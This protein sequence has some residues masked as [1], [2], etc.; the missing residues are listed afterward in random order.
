MFE[1]RRRTAN[2]RQQKQSK[3]TLRA[4]LGTRAFAVKTREDPS[5]RK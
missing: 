4:K 2:P 3:E 1:L 5:I